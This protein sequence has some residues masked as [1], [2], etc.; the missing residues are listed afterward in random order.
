[1]DDLLKLTVYLERTLNAYKKASSSNEIVAKLISDSLISMMSDISKIINTEKQSMSQ[2]NDNDNY[3]DEKIGH[4]QVNNENHSGTTKFG[5]NELSNDTNDENDND[6]DY[7]EENISNYSYYT[8]ITTH[9][10]ENGSTE[11]SNGPLVTPTSPSSGQNLQL[12]EGVMHSL[13]EKYSE[14][15]VKTVDEKITAR[16]TSIKPSTDELESDSTTTSNSIKST[17]PIKGSIPVGI[18]KN[19][20]SKSRFV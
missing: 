2:D 6:N 4:K 18:S 17:K 8:A 19:K 5:N 3:H 15:L 20:V 16:F 9:S 11:I 10:N 14:L 13:L 12:P 1:M 7:H